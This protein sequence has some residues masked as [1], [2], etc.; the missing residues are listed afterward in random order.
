MF[1][2]LKKVLFI[3]SKEVGY[4]VFTYLHKLE[5]DSITGCVT[6]QDSKDTRSYLTWFYDYC[7]KNRIPIEVLKKASVLKDCINK[8]KPDICFVVGWYTILDKSLLESVPGGFI[9][10]HA[11]ILPAYRGSA[12]LVW[13]L[14]NKEKET[15]W[16]LFQFNENMDEGDIWLQEKVQINSNDYISD[17]IEK[18]VLSIEARL[19]KCY[20]DILNDRILPYRQRIEGVSYCGRRIPVDGKINWNDTAENVYAFIRSQSHPYPGAYTIL[21]GEKVTIWRASIANDIIY[22]TPGQVSLFRECKPV[23]SCGDKRAII[24]TDY[25]F[26]VSS[27][28]RNFSLS[29]RFDSY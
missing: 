11:S 25:I 3:G 16:S 4:R 28:K 27:E 6:L 9:G 7:N 20:I 12:P 23:V 21:D 24:L 10:I 17:L 2:I 22:G 8:F 18:T 13:A 14:I 15:G 26:Q 5:P 29:T 19:G 1:L